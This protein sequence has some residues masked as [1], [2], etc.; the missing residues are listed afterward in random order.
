M[1]L[2][3]REERAGALLDF[4]FKPEE[5]RS[6]DRQPARLLNR[7][8]GRQSRTEVLSLNEQAVAQRAEAE[9]GEYKIR[10]RCSYAEAR[11]AVRIAKPEL[12]GLEKK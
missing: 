10:N 1:G 4:G 9:I 12:F 7:G 2:R 3:N 6:T 8:E 11:N 5:R